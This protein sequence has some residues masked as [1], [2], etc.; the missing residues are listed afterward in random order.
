MPATLPRRFL[1][2]ILVGGGCLPLGG[3]GDSVSSAPG[4]AFQPITTT[5]SI[6]ATRPFPPPGYRILAK[7]LGMEMKSSPDLFRDDKQLP[8]IIS[9]GH[10]A[11]MEL[12]GIQS[13]DQQVIYIADCDTR[14]PMAGIHAR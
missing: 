10:S 7:N 1:V 8:E 2:P 11:I 12:R 3:C 6:P 13:S 5:A 4:S 14:P 9:E